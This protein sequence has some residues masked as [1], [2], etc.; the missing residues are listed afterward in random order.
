MLTAFRDH[1]LE[2]LGLD[3]MTFS[4]DDNIFGEV[5]TV[6]LKEDGAKTTVTD[7]TKEEYVTYETSLHHPKPKYLTH[8][9]L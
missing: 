3:D 8:L 4:T 6:S 5:K 7:E 1:K 2:D 9:D